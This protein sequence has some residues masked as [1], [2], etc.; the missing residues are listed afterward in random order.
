[1][2]SD[3]EIKGSEYPFHHKGQSL[4]LSCDRSIFWEDHSAL[5]VS[6]LHLGK[7]GHFRKH[8]IPVPSQI[9]ISDLQRV[10]SL[11]ERYRPQ[12]ILFLGD[13]F[14]SDQNEEW[15]DFTHW[16]N[17]HSNLEQILILGNHDILDHAQYERTKVQLCEEYLHGPFEFTHE[18]RQS[19]AYN[20]SGHI[21][22]S[23]RLSGLARQGVTLPCFYFGQDHGLLPAFG[24]FTGNH[25]IRAKA[26]DQVFAIGE[27]LLIGLVG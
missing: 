23:I 11:I 24:E 21:H 12:R 25:P 13:L 19:K 1:M 22:P 16:S 2:R 8:G 27:D 14:H 4:V 15:Q 3:L 20:I 6:D 7:A 18:T 17:F 10:N 5:V 26:G 9:H